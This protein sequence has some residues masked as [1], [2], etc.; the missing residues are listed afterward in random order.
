MVQDTSFLAISASAFS[1]VNIVPLLPIAFISMAV[2]T[3]LRKQY[4]LMAE[5]TALLKRLFPGQFTI[6][7]SLLPQ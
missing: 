4:V 5:L 3:T 6:T 2:T 1:I 7:A